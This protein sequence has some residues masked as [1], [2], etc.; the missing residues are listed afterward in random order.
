MAIKHLDVLKLLAAAGLVEAIDGDV[1]RCA[2]WARLPPEAA[3]REPAKIGAEV[4]ENVLLRWNCI[5]QADPAEVAPLYVH[6]TAL[7]LAVCLHRQ[8]FADAELTDAAV[9]A[10]AALN[11]AVALN[12]VF[13]RRRADIEALLRSPA[14]MPARRPSHAKAHTAWR[15][16]DV[17]GMQVGDRHHAF[18]VLEVSQGAPIVEFYDIVQDTPLAWEHLQGVIARGKQ[19]N[20]GCEYLDRY[21]LYRLQYQPDPAHQFRLL[22]SGIAQGPDSAHLAR[23]SGLYV[24]TDVFRMTR[25]LLP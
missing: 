7:A 9:A 21:A 23:H 17:V 14:L 1:K 11:A 12:D 5:L 22:A 25:D 8:G 3:E 2:L 6:K 19:L 10:I 18:H 13:H 4:I 20:D 15:A 24:V 16:G